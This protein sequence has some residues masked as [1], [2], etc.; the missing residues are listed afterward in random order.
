MNINRLIIFVIVAL[1]VVGAAIY[2]TDNNELPEIDLTPAPVVNEDEASMENLT[3][4]KIEDVVIGTGAE[5]AVGDD[6]TVHYV[7]TLEDGTV[8]DSSRDRGEP[9]TF[10]LNPGGLIQ[11]WIDGI[12]GMK[13]GGVRKLT[14]PASLGYGENGAGPIP[15]N[16]TLYFEVELVKVGS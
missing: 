16:A 10:G 2:Y 11:G 12:P 6:I 15:P 7:G 14:I 13:E 5:V 8:F 1:V 9:A 3:E 4:V